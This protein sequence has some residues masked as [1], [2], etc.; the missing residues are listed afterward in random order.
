MAEEFVDAHDPDAHARDGKEEGNAYFRSGAYEEAATA[1]TAALEVAESS[2]LRAALFANRAASYGKLEKR[3]NVVAD[4]TAALELDPAYVKA[5][6]RRAH[7]YEADEKLEEAI[8]DLKK[9]DELAPSPPRRRH[10][11]DLEK[12]RE[13]R[14]QQLRD[15]AL[16]KLK[17][18]GNSVLGHFGMSLDSFAMEQTEGGG[19]NISYKP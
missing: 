15:E 13:T 19:Y 12:R 11:L 5:L 16:G 10:I 2:E 1:Y 8:A 9:A 14:D 6:V 7:A 17:D 3:E 4:C 18:L